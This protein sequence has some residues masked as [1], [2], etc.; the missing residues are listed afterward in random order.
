MV[1]SPEPEPEPAPSMTP[2]PHPPRDTA[3]TT[4]MRLPGSVRRTS[5]INMTWPDGRDGGLRLTGRAR[6]LLTP[7][8]GSP[9]VLS[10][11]SV[12][13]GV[14]DG[15]QLT[16]ITVSPD[17]PAAGELVGARGGGGYRKAL[18][19][20]LPGELEAGTPLYY[21]L[22][23]VAGCTLIAGFA[24]SRHGDWL[25][26]GRNLPPGG[27]GPSRPFPATSR[28]CAG[29]GPG[30]VSFVRMER[31]G[32]MGHNLT[33]AVEV[34]D[35]DDAWSWH[36]IDP[37]P[38][39]CMRRR[40]RVDVVRS[41][42]DIQVEAMFR[43]ACWDPDGTEES[44]HEY[45]LEATVDPSSMVLTS[46]SARPRSLPFPDCQSAGGYVDKLVGTP[47]SALRRQVTKILVGA[48]CC[49]HL[50]D[51]LRALAEVPVLV[52]YLPTDFA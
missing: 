39:V 22:D 44:L 33:P 9:A 10:E 25:G 51:M 18:D 3:R 37:A 38:L 24:W 45:S 21:L 11:A 13:V 34:A 23:D 32:N 50:N 16:S 7:V 28:V 47:M 4:P 48:E 43:D 20:A 27:P 8:S 5:H 40:R 36:D 35:P 15:R 42:G 19:S 26:S 52:G 31:D 1:R 17:R 46:I 49:T 6:D 41:I 2:L 14:G 12:V 30:S 29:L